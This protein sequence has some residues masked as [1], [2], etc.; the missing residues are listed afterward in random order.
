MRCIRVYK[1]VASVISLFDMVINDTVERGTNIK[2]IPAPIKS[3]IGTRF[4]N[5]TS[6]EIWESNA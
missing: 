2:A 6:S 5:A 1:L 3:N 4:E